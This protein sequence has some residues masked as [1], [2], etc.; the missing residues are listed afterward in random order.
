[1]SCVRAS[2]QPPHLGDANDKSNKQPVTQQCDMQ[3]NEYSAVI[4]TTL[5]WHRNRENIRIID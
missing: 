4:T 5:S 3:F 1:M 2:Y